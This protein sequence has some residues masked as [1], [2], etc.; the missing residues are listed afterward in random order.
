MD[1]VDG[2]HEAFQ[3][4]I[5]LILGGWRNEVKGSDV[6]RTHGLDCL[7]LVLM[8]IKRS[9]EISAEAGFS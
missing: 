1:A 4:Q 8:G 7:W 9:I 2:L 3:E 6:L 5:F